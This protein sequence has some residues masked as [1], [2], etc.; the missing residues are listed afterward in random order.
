MASKWNHSIRVR[1]FEL[2][3]K[4]FGPFSRT[5][6]RLTAGVAPSLAHSDIKRGYQDIYDQMIREGTFVLDG[7][8]ASSPDALEQ[9][10]AW[11]TTTQDPTRI[12]P[13]HHKIQRQ[14][15]IAA[16]EAGFM[17]MNDICYLET[18]AAVR[19]AESILTPR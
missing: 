8:A 18:A 13:G 19:A 2:V 11:C 1:L 10:V 16:Y 6:W 4:E 3:T 9:Q 14:T 17:Q 7:G 15:R 5:T 12:N